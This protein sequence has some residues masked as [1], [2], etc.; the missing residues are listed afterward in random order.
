MPILFYYP[1]GGS[2]ER[3]KSI[4]IPLCLLLTGIGIPLC[5]AGSKEVGRDLDR[6]N[7]IS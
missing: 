3:A 7:M 2:S 4:G 6:D 5:L 1:I